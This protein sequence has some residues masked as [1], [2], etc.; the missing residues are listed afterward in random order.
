MVLGRGIR[1]AKEVHVRQHGVRVTAAF[2]GC[3]FVYQLLGKLLQAMF[4]S[5]RGK[6]GHSSGQQLHQ[7]T[8]NCHSH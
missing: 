6:W 4:V 3:R 2:L 7:S 8:A 5:M 1:A